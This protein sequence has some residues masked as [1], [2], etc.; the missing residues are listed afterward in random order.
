[1]LS[2]TLNETEHKQTITKFVGVKEVILIAP[3][4]PSV[5]LVSVL[6][7]NQGGFTPKEHGSYNGIDC[8][9]Q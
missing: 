8:V 6:T 5:E 4:G 9:Y 1:M 3:A 7:I 2:I